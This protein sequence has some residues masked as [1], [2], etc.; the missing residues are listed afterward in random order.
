M[1]NYAC[2]YA[3]APAAAIGGD[4]CETITVDNG[5]YTVHIC[6]NEEAE[7]EDEEAEEENEEA[8]VEDEE[9]EK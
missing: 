2:K 7:V 1:H 5:K 6:E 3:N 9:E 4:I 8:E